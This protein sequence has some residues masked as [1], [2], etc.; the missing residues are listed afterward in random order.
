MRTKSS[1]VGKTLL[2]MLMSGSLLSLTDVPVAEAR[3][4]R[5]CESP[6][7]VRWAMAAG[8][9]KAQIPKLMRTMYKESRCST[10]ASNSCCSGLMQIHKIHLKRLGMRRL[11]LYNPFY[12]LVAAHNVWKRAG[13]GAWDGGGA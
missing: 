11:D 13:W 9:P 7:M 12:N 10:F 5:S 4:V 2:I 6:R 8:W 1:F 3:V